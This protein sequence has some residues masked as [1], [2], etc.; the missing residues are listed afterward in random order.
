MN[1]PTR[2]AL[3]LSAALLLLAPPLLAACSPICGVVNAWSACYPAIDGDDPAIDTDLSCL[4]GAGALLSTPTDVVRFGLATVDGRLLRPETRELLRTPVRLASGKTTGS[5]LGW[6][7]ESASL[8]PEARPTTVY[9]QQANAGG[10]ST[11]FITLPAHG[12]VVAVT[13]NVSSASGLRALALRLA[14]LFAWVE[15]PQATAA[16]FP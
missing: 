16:H 10:G 3:P 15:P 11:S 6:A 12:L 1:T 9:G 4:Q 8:G 2:R 7:I 5:G 13:T 14:D